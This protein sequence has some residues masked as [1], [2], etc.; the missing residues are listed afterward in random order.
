MWEDAGRIAFVQECFRHARD[1]NPEATL[2][3]NDYRTDAEYEAL[4]EQLVDE[5]GQSIYDVIGIQSHQHRE[6]WTNQKIWEVCERFS[7]FGAPLHFTE[8]TILSG[9]PGWQGMGRAQQWP[10]TEQR[11]IWQADEVERFYTMLFSHPAVEAITWW[12]FSDRHA[13]QGAP[14]GF[15]REDMS[16]K[17]AYDR[18]LELVKNRWWT[19]EAG[20][21]DTAGVFSFRGF[22]GKYRVTVTHPEGPKVERDLTLTKESPNQLVIRL[23]P[24]DS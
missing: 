3:I 2:L 7:R 16:A 4:I 8:V 21:T 11:E 10:S 23:S 14:A 12:D 24:E 17:P 19:R 1:A 15:L 13:W 9:E 22:L 6:T 18:L 5:Q 20:Q